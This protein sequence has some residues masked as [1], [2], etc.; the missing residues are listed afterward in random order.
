MI[1]QRTAKN[2]MN[3]LF[4]L[5]PHTTID[6]EPGVYLMDDRFAPRSSRNCSQIGTSFLRKSM[7]DA[8]SIV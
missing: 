5:S 8:S 1:V 2:D 6:D 3:A 4:A 7:N